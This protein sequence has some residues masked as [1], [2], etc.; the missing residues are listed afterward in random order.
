[1]EDSTLDEAF[2]ELMWERHCYDGFPRCVSYKVE[3]YRIPVRNIDN[4]KWHVWQG[5]GTANIYVDVY[6]ERAILGDESLL[7]NKIYIDLDNDKADKA[8]KTG[9]FAYEDMRSIVRFFRAQYKYTPRVY[10]S[11]G[12]GFAVYLDFDEVPLN[13]CKDTL[14]EFYTMLKDQLGLKTIDTTSV[15]DDRR[16]SRLPYTVHKKSG[17]LCTPIDPNWSLKDI[18][19]YSDDFIVDLK[20]QEVVIGNCE[21]FGQSLKSLDDVVTE[22]IK[23]RNE[24]LKLA[25]PLE[26]KPDGDALYTRYFDEVTLLQRLGPTY[27]EGRHRTLWCILV[28]RLIFLLADGKPMKDLPAEEQESIINRVEARAMEWVFLTP[29]HDPDGT[30]RK[31]EDNYR[32]YIRAI[33]RQHKQ[34]NWHPWNI[35]SFWV[36]NP[37][38]VKY[39]KA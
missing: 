38:L 37:D 17:R 6:P 5:F 8:E 13:H 10:Y 7:C 31:T 1:V 25:P 14:T 30:E 11:G 15:G 35:G 39:W 22:R 9:I 21:S 34:E 33:C 27:A 36:E 3:R 4:L 29:T 19:G 18:L 28:P 2:M 32:A 20:E 24:Q 23:A 16:I 12:R 26:F